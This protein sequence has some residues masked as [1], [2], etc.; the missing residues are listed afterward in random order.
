MKYG[1]V[2]DYII[3]AIVILVLEEILF[4]ILPLDQIISKIKIIFSPIIV[5]PVDTSVVVSAVR[6]HKKIYTALEKACRKIEYKRKYEEQELPLYW[7]VLYRAVYSLFSFIKPLCTRWWITLISV[8]FVLISPGVA[9]C[10]PTRGAI[11]GCRYVSNVIGTNFLKLDEGGKAENSEE[12]DSEEKDT[13]EIVDTSSDKEYDSMQRK[14]TMQESEIDESENLQM[15]EKVD[16]SREKKPEGYSFVLAE[17]G[18]KSELEESVEKAVFQTKLDKKWVKQY[19]AKKSDCIK[20]KKIKKEDS[21]T[22]AK[23]SRMQETF[24]DKVNATA[25]MEYLDEW[26]VMAPNSIALDDRMEQRMKLIEKMEKEEGC[27]ENW[28]RIA[29]DA[30]YYAIEYQKQTTNQTAILYYYTYSIYYCMKSLEYEMDDET[31]DMIYKYM[32]ERYHDISSAQGMIQ[33]EYT[34]NA[35][36]KYEELLKSRDVG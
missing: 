16:S 24:Q 20:D 29:N 1:R 22:M 28:W 11:L 33:E 19:C 34:E 23:L 15:D 10:H 12:K 13:E 5:L 18:R 30:Q 8:V 3:T 6:N 14:M 21:D 4:N 32:A 17:P 9:Y 7:V 26:N 35:Q 2:R 25:S 31:Q 27:Y 36:K